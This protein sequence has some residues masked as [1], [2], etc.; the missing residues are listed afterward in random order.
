MYEN[1]CWLRRRDEL[2]ITEAHDNFDPQNSSNS[3]CSLK[4]VA[5]GVA[6]NLSW[7]EL[8]RVNASSRESAMF[9][10]LVSACRNVCVLDSIWI[11]FTARSIY[12]QASLSSPFTG[13]P[14]NPVRICRIGVELYRLSTFL[15]HASIPSPNPR[16]RICRVSDMR[17]SLS[18]SSAYA[19]PPIP[20][21]AHNRGLL[22]GL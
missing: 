3:S 13:S 14:C 5:S 10:K 20:A 7:K 19:H 18:L 22:V 8:K 6:P 15:H 1:G 11:S 12:L 4:S 2:V 21:S 16:I 17:T 9:M